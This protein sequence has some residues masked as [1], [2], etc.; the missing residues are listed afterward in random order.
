MHVFDACFALFLQLGVGCRGKLSF[1]ELQVHFSTLDGGRRRRMDL[2][3]PS[4]G[5]SAVEIGVGVGGAA[6]GLTRL[7]ARVDKIKA[8]PVKKMTRF[9]WLNMF[10]SSLFFIPVWVNCIIA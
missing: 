7:H 5:Y 10:F 2:Q 8:K 3:F 4:P 9:R 1:G 6:V